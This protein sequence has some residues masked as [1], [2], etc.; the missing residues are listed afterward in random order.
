[1]SQQNE[2]QQ[3]EEGKLKNQEGAVKTPAPQMHSFALLIEARI[4]DGALEI[5]VR[6]GVKDDDFASDVLSEVLLRD[7]ELLALFAYASITSLFTIGGEEKL[8]A[9]IKSTID[10]LKQEDSEPVK[11]D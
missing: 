8:M 1:M 4:K 2:K 9:L 10:E 11:N 5:E 7:K 6:K 3:Q